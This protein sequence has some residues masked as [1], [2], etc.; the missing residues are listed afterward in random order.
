MFQGFGIIL[1]NM[2][3]LRNQVINQEKQD[4][5]DRLGNYV[6]N[7][8]NEMNGEELCL[9]ILNYAWIDNDVFKSMRMLE[10]AD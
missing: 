1:K 2:T 9:C 8:L 7:H 10:K 6:A 3:Y 5:I 4:I